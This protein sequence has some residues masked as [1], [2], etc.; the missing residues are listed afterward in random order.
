MRKKINIDGWLVGSAE[1]GE[2][3][4]LLLKIVVVWRVGHAS[5]VGVV[6]GVR[7]HHAKWAEVI[8][9]LSHHVWILLSHGVVLVGIGRVGGRRLLLRVDFDLLPADRPN[10]LY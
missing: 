1:H 10:N 6:V 3:S 2:S 9:L 5:G 4:H 8:R 7:I